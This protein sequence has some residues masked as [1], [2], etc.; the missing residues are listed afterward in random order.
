MKT[1]KEVKSMKITESQIQ[2][3]RGSREFDDVIKAY[4]KKY[5]KHLQVDTMVYD[6]ES[7]KYYMYNDQTDYTLNTKRLN[8]EI[9]SV[10]GIFDILG[11]EEE[12]RESSKHLHFSI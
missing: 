12:N 11:I 7:G 1:M 5:G 6:K 10:E 4:Y 8:E 9:E 2:I 3:S